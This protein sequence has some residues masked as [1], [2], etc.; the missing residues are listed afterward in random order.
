MIIS[1]VNLCKKAFRQVYMPVRKLFIY[2]LSAAS[3][4][5]STY[6]SISCHNS[7]S[8]CLVCDEKGIRIS[9]C[10]NPSP[11]LTAF[12]CLLIWLLLIL[13]SLLQQLQ[14][15]NRY[16]QSSHTSFCHYQMGHDGYL[17][18]RT[19]ALTGCSFLNISQ[20]SYPILP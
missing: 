8:P 6:E 18:T 20:S 11:V 9:S 16:L 7:L 3:S 19:P 15:C 14:V 13:S 1:F 4:C 2:S 12:T 5:G 17:S 10:L